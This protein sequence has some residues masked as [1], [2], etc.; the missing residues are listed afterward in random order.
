MI[1][2]W[3]W[4]QDY[5]EIS[6]PRE[7]VENR[8]MMSGL[9]HEGTETVADDFAI[10]L[11]VTSNRPDC[12][13]HIGVAR[14]IAVLFDQ[15]LKVD[16][17]QPAESETDVNKLTSVKIDCPE[18]C[19]RYTARVVRGV[20]VGPSP[21]WMVQR[22]AAIGVNSVNN[23]VDITNYVM[24]ESGQPLHAFDFARIKGGIVVGRA[25]KD[26]EIQAIDHKTY[27]LDRDMCV[28]ADHERPVA[29]AGVMGGADTEVSQDTTD[30][31]IEVADFAPLPIRSAARQLTLQSPSSYRF[32]RT[33]DPKGIDWASRRCAELI[34]EIAGGELA[35]GVV[36]V[37]QSIPQRA[38]ITLRYSEIE[39][40]LGIEISPEQTKSIL[41]KL[42]N[43]II[44]GQSEFVE[45]VPPSWRR[46]LTRE[47]DLIEEVARIYG[48]DKIPEN[49]RVPMAAT[50]RKDEDRAIVK[51]RNVLVGAGF[52]EAMTTTLIPELW[53]NTFSPWSDVEPLSASQS[54]H[55]VIDTAWQ[56]IGRTDLL[57]RSLVPS[58]LESRRINEHRSGIDAHL[59]EIA[60]VYLTNINETVDEYWKLAIIGSQ[61]FY[62]IKGLIES[63]AQSLD[64]AARIETDPFQH[65]LFDT[66]KSSGLLLN[67]NR[68][69]WIG[70]VSNKGKSDFSLRKNVTVA[71][72]DLKA[73]TDIAIPIPQ[74]QPISDFPAIARDFNF[75]LADKV[76]WANL[77]TTVRESGGDLVESVLYRETFR[78][79][80]KDGEGKK[81]LLL[82][83]TLRSKSETLTG[84]VADEVCKKIVDQCH[85]SHDAVLVG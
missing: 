65:E 59:F 8:L 85:K 82:S 21:D 63:I 68:L 2:S 27:K 5:V 64:P 50:V 62:G 12:L 17:P 19:Y 1:V 53:S 83:V 58:L 37:G 54:M 74:Q 56:N 22:L 23:I 77:E 44:N 55:G 52:F 47:I 36:D 35:K 11:E 46:D 61:D 25:K 30:I 43:E 67:G 7:E 28:I 26:E 45:V 70:E 16:D 24:F 72:V 38:S 69:G 18:M 13:G 57:R 80:K 60:N 84:S 29:I 3:K 71:E 41:S 33:V 4:L 40:V 76:H 6:A 79:T 75:I 10:D 66:S 73:L 32:E 20:K 15:E 51:I 31:L 81:R 34:L 48:Y 14:E 49:A 39:R 42:G 78:D 9:N